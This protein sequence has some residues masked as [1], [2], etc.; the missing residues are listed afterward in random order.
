MKEKAALVPSYKDEP[1]SNTLHIQANALVGK[2]TE[3]TLGQSTP[4]RTHPA[5]ASR[6]TE[7][8]LLET[9]NIK[10]QDTHKEPTEGGE[11]V[12]DQVSGCQSCLFFT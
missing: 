12:S 5:P 10:R 8:R 3:G 1:W 9:L 11:K 2:V 4:H 6:N 7:H